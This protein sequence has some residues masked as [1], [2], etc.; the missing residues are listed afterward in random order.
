LRLTLSKVFAQQLGYNL[1]H[2]TPFQRGKGLQEFPL[3]ILDSDAHHSHG[4]RSCSS[5]KWNVGY[6]VSN[7]DK[8]LAKRWDFPYLIPIRS[9]RSPFGNDRWPDSPRGPS[10][11]YA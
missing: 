2:G 7:V 9:I 4:Y 11:I 1:G 6:P 5:T 3:V 10:P 8:S